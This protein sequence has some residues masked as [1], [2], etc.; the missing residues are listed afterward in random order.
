M[1]KAS[2]K[3][4][5]IALYALPSLALMPVAATAQ[6]IDVNSNTTYQVVRGFG[7]HNGVGWIPDL[8]ADQVETAFGTGPGQVGLSI[9]RMRIDSSRQA[10]ER[11]VPTARLAKAKGV[12]LFATPWSPPASMKTNNNII[13]GRLL[14]ADYPAYATH[15]LDFAAMMRANGAQLHGISIQNEPDIAVTYESCLW[16]PDELIGFLQSEGGRFDTVKLMGPESYRFSKA[17]SDPILN[18]AA[19]AQHLDI[20]SGHL[21]GVTP[22]DDPL[23]RGKGKELWMTEHYTDSSSDA[24]D[25][26]KALPVG[27]ELHKSMLSNHSAY[28]WW[29]IRRSYGLLTEDGMVSKRGHIMAQ[30]AKH[31]R[32]GYTRIGATERPYHDVLVTAYKGGDGKLVVVAVNNGAQRRTVNLRFASN[33]PRTLLRYMT[34]ATANQQYLGEHAVTNGAASLAVEPLSVTTLV[35]QPALLDATGSLK[36]SRSG[37]SANRFT[38]AFSGSISFTNVNPNPIRGAALQLVLEGLPQDV[39]LGNRNGEWNGAPYLTLP[40]AEIAP[41][42]TVTVNTSFANPSM[43]NISY[44]PRVLSVTY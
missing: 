29:Y 1:I 12:T 34:S 43:A 3:N 14:P 44:T 41:G 28:V 25:W 20:V 31:V 21:Y 27:V 9:M 16:S 40:V 4:A 2:L 26:V 5:V 33:T 6:T 11:Q 15:L 17:M 39:T 32:P 38:G 19:A 24:N 37:L 8:T 22:S 18:N 30:Y 42:A 7:G 13:G 36:I 23:A 35:N 10:W